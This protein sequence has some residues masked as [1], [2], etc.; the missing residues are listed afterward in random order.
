MQSTGNSFARR[1][2]V[3]ASLEQTIR[4]EGGTDE[5]IAREAEIFLNRIRERAGLFVLRT[6]DYFGFFHRNKCRSTFLITPSK[7]C[8]FLA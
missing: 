3:M 5:E 8:H 7:F 4:S 1:D 6:G 2:E